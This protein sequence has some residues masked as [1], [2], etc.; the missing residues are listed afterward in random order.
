MSQLNAQAQKANQTK[1]QLSLAL[2]SAQITN[3]NIN[4]NFNLSNHLSSNSAGASTPEAFSKNNHSAGEQLRTVPQPAE[5]QPISA[6]APPPQGIQQDPVHLSPE[7][8]AGSQ[9]HLSCR[10]E[11]E[12]PKPEDGEI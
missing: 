1:R 4:F 8:M 12:M 3:A 9:R 6:T 7:P 5:H 2:Q 11:H 10:H